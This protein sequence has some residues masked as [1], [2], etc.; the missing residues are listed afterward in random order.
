MKLIDE[1]K[2]ALKD[3]EERYREAFKGHG[4]DYWDDDISNAFQ[5]IMTFQRAIAEQES[6][7]TLYF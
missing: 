7:Q 6:L 2:A 4:Y 5:D 3:A 1:Y